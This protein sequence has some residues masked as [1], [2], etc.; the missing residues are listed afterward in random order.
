MCGIVGIRRFDG[1][2][3]DPHLLRAMTDRLVH[4]GPDAEGY[5]SD[6]PIGFGHRRLSIIDLAG[7]TQP[8]ASADGRCH[9][10]FNGE[11][12][13]YR[14]LRRRF[15]YPYQTDGDTETILACFAASGAAG[16]SE[17]EGQF[18][19]GLHD[20]GEGVLWLARDRVGILPLYYYVD[21]TL[22]A[23][24]S[25][26]KALLP[27]LPAARVDT[28]SL[29][30]YLS[31][32]AVAAPYT[33]FEG[34]RKLP[35]AHL[36]R[37]G[38]R[39]IE[40]PRR[41]WHFPSQAPLP[42]SPS[43]AV[44]QVDATLR[45]AVATALVA[46]VPV[47]AYLSGG[48]DS[49]LIVA[50]MSDLRQGDGVKTFSA[51]FGDPRYDELP[52]ARQV[53]QLLGTEH[54]EVAV[55]PDDFRALWRRLTWHRDAPISEPADIAVFRLAELARR[56]VTVVLSGEGSDELFGG[57]PKHRYALASSMAGLVPARL[58]STAFRAMERSLPASAGRLR[59]ALRALS[60]RDES[61][62]FR[63][64]F[65]PFTGAE[66]QAL[67]QD[68]TRHPDA[69]WPQEPEG[70]PLRRMLLMDVQN[71]L[72]DNLLER[73]DRMSMAASLELR[74]PFLDRRMLEL[75]FSLPSSLK[76]HKD[77]TKWLVK[78]VALRYLP[79][80]IVNRRKVGFRVPL[81]AWFR[82]GLEAFAW[83]SLTSQDALASTVFDRAQVR[84]LLERHRSGRANEEIRIWT[85]LCLE[86]WYQEF[87]GSDGPQVSG[88]C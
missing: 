39:G 55:T 79:E 37:V 72:P 43:E 76:V 69:D 34:I 9:L 65:S 48:V 71:W 23:F 22:L 8:M 13:N 57:Y 35:P 50:L 40:E 41:Y 12:L 87:F 64:W 7:S 24:A 77:T 59:I 42:P 61:S 5:W 21:A 49:S 82:E 11:I 68:A 83:D 88:R 54:H 3:V 60:G 1:G 19:L 2:E 45:E 73:G 62:R 67:L 46:D 15:S 18:A 80:S 81:D 14:H 10:T 51:G 52:Y 20:A 85:L 75:A 44:D 86:V 47:G 31:Q 63:G 56:S 25:E 6:G 28:H 53:S 70:D 27:A 16:L 78:Q 4:R 33:L 30:A 26:I 32:R 38:E 29:D 58:R 66:R 84:R 36:L 17:L 74:P